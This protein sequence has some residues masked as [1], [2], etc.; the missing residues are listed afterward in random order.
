M[1]PMIVWGDRLPKIARLD[2]LT[3]AARDTELVKTYITPFDRCFL[4]R[5]TL[6]IIGDS[7]EARARIMYEEDK[8]L[9]NLDWINEQIDELKRLDPEEAR[10][11]L[12]FRNTT[13]GR[14]DP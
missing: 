3:P 14:T 5:F 8:R 11:L 4:N 1:A 7:K 6:P 2:W 9:E 13:F 12:S 10:V